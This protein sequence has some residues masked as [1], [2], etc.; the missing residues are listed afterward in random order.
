MQT[1]K[2][3]LLAAWIT[4]V[5]GI[6]L[7]VLHYFAGSPDDPEGWLSAVGFGVP[8]VATGVLALIGVRM[9]RAELVFV[10]G[11]ILVPMSLLSI[12]LIPLLAPAALL[13][14]HAAGSG[15]APSRLMVP[16][17]LAL[18]ILTA[19]AILVFHQDPV[20]WT[21]ETGGG[22][23]SNIVTKAEATLAIVAAVA[24]TASA[25]VWTLTI[26]RSSDAQV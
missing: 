6:G 20:T 22:G 3:A 11:L 5:G 17:A 13:I 9:K 12:V 24:V 7:M 1:T 15:I 14:A 2:V 21:T 10:A 8:F 25:L 23:S 4:M 18:V 19:F 16:A 26:G